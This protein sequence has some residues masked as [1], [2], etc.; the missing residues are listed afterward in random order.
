MKDFSILIKLLKQ[1]NVNRIW[2]NNIDLRVKSSLLEVEMKERKCIIYNKNKLFFDEQLFCIYLKNFNDFWLN[3]IKCLM[4]SH[5]KYSW[6]YIIIL[7]VLKFL[8]KFNIFQI[9]VELR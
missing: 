5:D 3:L 8:I 9:F 2:F 7:F 6:T 1:I 4:N